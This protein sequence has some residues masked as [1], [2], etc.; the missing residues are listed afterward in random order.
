[1]ADGKIAIDLDKIAEKYS[2][3]NNGTDS[4]KDDYDLDTL[5]NYDARQTLLER[6][7]KRGQLSMMDLYLLNK[8]ERD[9][10]RDMLMQQQ[11]SKPTDI[12]EIIKKSQEPFIKQI[13][14]MKQE[15]ERE[16]QEAKF[17]S[18]QREIASIRDLITNGSGKKSEN[19]ELLKRF[20]V[21]NQQ[22]SD[23]KEKARQKE[24][25]RFQETFMDQ[26]DRVNDAIDG[27]KHQPQSKGVLEQLKELN[28]L[29]KDLTEALGI[30]EGGK[31]E[32]AGIGD[33][34]DTF[35]E[36]GPKIAKSISTMRD[37]FRGEDKLEDDVPLDSV[38]TNIPERARPRENRSIVPPDITEFLNQGQDTTD[39]Y[40]DIT[41]VVW[42]N[43]ITGTPIHRADIEDLA[44]TDPDQV[45]EVMTQAYREIEEA[46]THRAKPSV[47]PEVP[48]QEVPPSMPEEEPDDIPPSEP[49]ETPAPQE[50]SP[51]RDA[52][53]KE[54]MDY[55]NSGEDRTDEDGNTQWVGKQTETYASEQGLLTK[56]KLIDEAKKDPVEFMKDVRAHLAT[57][58]EE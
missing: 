55:I 29:K 45:R 12:E 10:R 18:L 26:L 57:L 49:L 11:T 14:E 35:A 30:K 31:E 32:E 25:E 33:L 17:E 51:D 1:M 21:L 24:Q 28:A 4:K 9:E 23:E 8:M 47:R 53:L 50:D 54:A 22:L 6:M 52:A 42:K 16:K 3:K 40:K 5:Y 48:K 38:P 41:G 43:K 20:D 13:E 58:K 39:G 34:V 2:K 37:A 27:L 15:R 19:E 36:K 7:Q 46:K 44:I 56:E